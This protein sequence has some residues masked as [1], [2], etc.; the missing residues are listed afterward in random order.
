MIDIIKQLREKTGAGMMACKTALKEASGDAKKAID[1]LRKKGLSVAQKKSGRATKEGMIQSYI[2]T[3]GKIGV[4]IEI[5]CETD[6]VAR[7]ED[8]QAFSRDVAMQIAAVNP[9]YI[10]KDNVPA[11]IVEKEKEIIKAQISNSGGK[12]KPPQVMEKIV[13]GKLEKFYEEI[14]LMQQQFIKDQ[15]VKIKDLLVD[16]VGKI[17]ENISVRR[18]VR[19]QLGEEQG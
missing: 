4:L 2:H 3:G 15:N 16:L 14:C 1:I 5:N 7:N 19:Y 13:T 17:G 18:F 6:F 8:F 10:D 12:E 11:D 9:T